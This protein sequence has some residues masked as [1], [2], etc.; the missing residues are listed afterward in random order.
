MKID[1]TGLATK[2]IDS[3]INLKVSV[4]GESMSPVLRKGD[5]VYL[6]PVDSKDLSI[7]DI[8]L[9]KTGERMM[10]HRLVEICYKGSE[11]I[12]VTKGDTFSS[13]DFPINGRDIIGR[14][15][16]VEKWGRVFN[17]K[18]GI[19]SIIDRFA[20]FIS[21]LTTFF[22]NIK[23]WYKGFNVTE[24]IVSRSRED[25]FIAGILENKNHDNFFLKDSVDFQKVLKIARDNNISQKLYAVLKE[26]DIPKDFMAE[27]R[28][29]YLSTAVRNTLIYSEFKKVAEGF[30]DKEIDVIVM[31]GAALAELIYQDIGLRGMS[32]VDLLIRKED[33][34]RANDV[35][36][37]MGYYAV[38]LSRFDG[39][40]SYLTTC[41][42]R[43]KNPLHPSFHVHWHIVNSTVP[44][45]YSSRINMDEFWRDAAHVEISDVSVLTMSP[46]HFLIHLC[47]HAM[48]VT[49]SAS[50]LIYLMDIASLVN[51][52]PIH[53]SDGYSAPF[54]KG[55]I[56]G[57]FEIDWHKV[58]ET[59]K[60]YG[61]DRFVYNILS[62]TRLNM[63]LDVPEWVLERLKPKRMALGERL[64]HFITARG[65]GFSGLSYLVHLS[66]NKGIFKKISFIFRTL[67]PP[68]W[69]LAKRY[70]YSSKDK[71][72]ALL[73]LYRIE[74][75]AFHIFS[76][77]IRQLKGSN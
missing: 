53:P 21:P 46:H 51:N 5:A 34:K 75:I 52:P 58:V 44:A 59:S 55:G 60:D 47:E 20:Y 33:I 25:M 72:P 8:V 41:D 77:P 63:G 23:R 43:S 50:K 31:K 64:F 26:Q 6:E 32:D 35:L 1:Y 68:A 42:Y 69:V 37:D 39:S 29:D 40:D 61:L 71:N 15:Y 9:C 22:Y 18:K 65:K 66:M 3:S 45:P 62:L 48:R 67:F 76:L 12:F 30:K 54:N 13:V 38:D 17:L 74:E 27:L 57:G 28:R 2:L 14:V 4:I 10:A 11:T 36:E 49:H 56:K 19:F 7:G 16:A 73:Y 70:A 24:G